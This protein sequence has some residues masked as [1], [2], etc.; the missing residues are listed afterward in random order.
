MADK[1]TWKL[2]SRDQALKNNIPTLF[3]PLDSEL[4]CALQT[5]MIMFIFYS[6][7]GVVFLSPN[8]YTSLEIGFW[9]GAYWFINY[10]ICDLLRNN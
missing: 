7:Q 9:Q 10:H 5:A 2:F 4:H 6:A 3:F 1:L 8:V